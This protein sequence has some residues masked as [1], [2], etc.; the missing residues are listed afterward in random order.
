MPV[1][2]RSAARWAVL[3]IALVAV[4][5]DA[6]TTSTRAGLAELITEALDASAFNDAYWGAY[7]VNLSNGEVLYDRNAERRFIPA[8]NMKLLSTAAALDA[9]GPDFQYATRLYAD[10]PI[11]NGTL[12]G[13]LVVRGAGDPSFGGR[14]RDGDAL[15]V[16][17]QWADSLRALGIR[18]VEGPVVGD[19]DV[20]DNVPLG[21]GW[22]WDDL[23]WYYGAEI[24][25]LQFNEG[26]VHV[27]VRG[28]SPGQPARIVAEPDYGYVR[29]VN[30]STTT[31]GG[32]IREGYDRA[33][34]DNVFTVT[35]SVPAGRTETEDLSIVNPTDYFSS[36][37]IGVLRD[38]GIEVAGEAVDVDEWGR[39]PRYE[40]LTRVA[41]HISPSLAEIVQQT[42]EDSNNLYAEHL[43]RTMGAYVYRG[44]D[45]PTGS[46]FAGFEATKPFLQRLGVDP[47]SFRVAD[48][49]GL[50]ALNRL[51]PFGLVSILRGMHEHPDRATREAFE[52]SLPVGGYTGTLRNRYR[53]GDARG[54]V[55]AKTGYISGARTLSGYV[56]SERGDVLAFSLLCNN[57]TTSTS[58]VNQAQDQIVEL[59]ADYEGR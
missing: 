24:S 13:A 6:Q 30:R 26:T 1:R 2:F 59:L 41:T 4:R 37:L 10:G 25:G 31:A 50:S 46:A 35:A 36:T 27:E 20:F 54:N 17:R 12:L 18:R 40:M 47:E 5:A 11:Q 19:D 42:N 43:L 8:S 57:Y 16:F 21:Q 14:F 51:T 23:K 49:S 55:R 53:S 9:L 44:T 34:G 3:L 32:S 39:R 22:Q 38:H 33:L 56:T 52:A 48:G 28:T 7:V 15:G 58:R 29:F 45:L